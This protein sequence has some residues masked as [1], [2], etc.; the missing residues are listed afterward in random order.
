MFKSYYDDDGNYTYFEETKITYHS[1]SLEDQIRKLKRN[2]R[3]WKRKFKQQVRYEKTLIRD[4][5]DMNL[6]PCVIFI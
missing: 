3:D 1:D 5:N 2:L 4:I 6:A